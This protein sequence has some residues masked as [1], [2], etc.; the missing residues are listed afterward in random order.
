MGEIMEEEQL[1]MPKG[2]KIY[3]IV[4][5]IAVIALIIPASREKIFS[6][7]NLFNQ[8]QK[9]LELVNEFDIDKGLEEIDISKDKIIKWNKNELSFL[10]FNGFEVLKKESDFKDPIVYFGEELIYLMDKSTGKAQLMDKEGTNTRELDLKFPFS[11]FKEDGDKLYVYRK[12]GDTETV[13]I[14]NKEGELLKTHQENIPILSVIMGNKDQEYLAAVLDVDKDLK[15]MV[16]IYSIDGNDIGNL[17]FKDE[18]VIYSEFL[19]DKVLIATDKKVYLL[20]DSVLE[21]DKEIK[22]IK[23]IKVVD[24]EI[25]LLYNDKFEILNSKGDVKEEFVLETDLENIRLIE[26]GILLFGKRDILLPQK[27]HNILEF[28]SEEDIID[29]KYDEGKLLIQKEGKVAIYNIIE[30]GAN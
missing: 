17:E 16:G 7:L 28:K 8:S 18:L 1:K 29:V 24:K 13:D 10:D 5:L 21:W 26:E 27:K 3:L 22:D 19:R 9:Q 2:Y 12:D 20:K 30:K 15:S 25:Y 11:K 23:D 6:S 14:I 4:L